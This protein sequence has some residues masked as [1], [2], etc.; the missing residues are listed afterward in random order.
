MFARISNILQTLR[1][2]GL[3]LEL[4][5]KVQNLLPIWPGVEEIIRKKITTDC[6]SPIYTRG[7]DICIEN[8]ILQ[9]LA[10]LRLLFFKWGK[11]QLIL[12]IILTDMWFTTLANSNTTRSQI[13]LDLRMFT[14]HCGLWWHVSVSSRTKDLYKKLAIF[15][16]PGNDSEKK[17]NVQ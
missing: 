5:P 12:R 3:P 14:S 8:C 17:T 6:S 10:V 4:W 15:Y 2:G 16:W 13:W 7:I 11:D 9:Y 1:S